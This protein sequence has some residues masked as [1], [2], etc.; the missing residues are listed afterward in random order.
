MSVGRSH[1]LVMF[2]FDLLFPYGGDI[3]KCQH[4]FRNLVLMP[5]W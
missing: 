3:A 1:R 5:V 4:L 2:A